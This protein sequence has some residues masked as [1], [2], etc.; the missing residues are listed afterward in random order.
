MPKTTILSTTDPR[1]LPLARQVLKNHGIIAFP[2][3]TI[4]GLAADAFDPLAIERIFNVKQRPENKALPVLIGTL[5]QLPQLAL[6]ISEN[7]EKLATAFWPG[8]LTIV[9]PKNSD[10]P[11]ELSPYPTI[12][13]R[14]P[15]LAFT[16]E[17]LVQT[18]PLATTSANLSGGANPVSSQDVLDQLDGKIDLLLDGGSTPGPIASTVIDATKPQITILRQGSILMEDL[19]AVLGSST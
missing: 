4:Y 2:T 8:P 14:M 11:E 15:N 9:L 1:C 17:L 18:G 12:G 19:E 3:D 5:K 6:T 7:V 13:I 10:L 16:L